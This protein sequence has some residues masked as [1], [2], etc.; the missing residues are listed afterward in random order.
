[1]TQANCGT[2]FAR[3]ILPEEYVPLAGLCPNCRAVVRLEVEK[4]KEESKRS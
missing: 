1:M 2:C 4:A 3:Y